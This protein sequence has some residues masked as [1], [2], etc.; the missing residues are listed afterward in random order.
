VLSALSLRRRLLVGVVD[1][2]ALDS[3]IRGDS[4]KA[5]GE[6]FVSQA[7]CILLVV[8]GGKMD[9][10]AL[11]VANVLGQSF[12]QFLGALFRNTFRGVIILLP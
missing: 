5:M 8:A 9:H 10:D 4:V 6:Y 12:L 3:L 1:S 2:K 7:G 11:H